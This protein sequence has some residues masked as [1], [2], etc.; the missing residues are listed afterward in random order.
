[1]LWSASLL[2]SNA[3]ETLGAANVVVS[4]GRRDGPLVPMNLTIPPSTQ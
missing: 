4:Q 2:G 1:M 3:R